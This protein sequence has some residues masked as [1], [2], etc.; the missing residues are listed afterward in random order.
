MKTRRPLSLASLLRR[1]LVLALVLPVMLL[2]LLVVLAVQGVAIDG[3]IY[4]KP[5]EALLSQQLAREVRFN[6]ALDLRL[7]V[8]PSLV[9]RDARIGQPAGFGDDAFA[10]IGEL[11]VRLDLW[12]LL[13]QRL[14]ADALSASDVRVNL[15]QRADGS[16]NW[17]FGDGEPEPTP[18]AKAAPD[19]AL[20]ALEDAASIDIRQVSLERLQVSFR[21]VNDKP[22][23]FALDRFEARV[24]IDGPLSASAEGKVDQ[25]MPYALKITGG[26]LRDLVRGK[27]DWPLTMQLEFAGG[28]L[29]LDG[30]LGP[31]GSAL[32]FG[33]GTP[34]LARF[35]RVIDVALPDAGSAGVAG[36]LSVAPGRV[37]LTELSGAL[38]KSSLRGELHVDA[39]A[40][41]PKL[42]GTLTLPVLDL[43]PFLGQ[44][45]EE[46][47]PPDLRALYLSLS[48]ARLDLRALRDAD[49]D[50]Q[51]NVERWLSLPGDIQGARLHLKLEDGRLEVPLSA[52]V[53]GVP[54]KGR[55][56][57]NAA[58]SLPQV[59]LGLTAERSDVGGLAQLLT[60]LPGI[61]G[62]LGRLSVALAAEGDRGETLMKKLSV[63]LQL[64]NSRLTYGNVGEG[65]PVAFSVEQMR[66]ALPAAG[67]LEGRFTG[68]LLGKPL[69]ARLSGGDLLTSMKTGKTPIEVVA[70]SG[71]VV[72]RVTG[73][74]DAN[75]TG[76]A[77]QFSLGAPQAGEVAAWLGL[78]PTARA[79]LA[80][81]GGLSVEGEQW[82]LSHFVFQLGQSS[83]YAQAERTRRDGRWLIAGNVETTR[84]DVAELE[85]LMASPERATPRPEK[86]GATL[87]I[88]VL[89]VGVKLDDADL[90]L[91]VRGVQGTALAVGELGFDARLREGYMHSSPFF[92][93]VGGHRFEGA[94]MLDL[95]DAEPRVQL[96]L[97]AANVDV[98]RILRDLKLTKELEASVARLNL[99]LDTH[100]SRLSELLAN[101]RQIGEISGGRLVVRD[102]N[103]G[104]TASLVLDR[105]TLS[106]QPKAP[107]T[108]ALSGSLDAIPVDLSLQ[109]APVKDLLDPARRV[110]F[111]LALAAAGTQVRLKGTMDRMIDKRDVELALTASGERFDALDKLLRVSLPPWGPWSLNGRFRMSARGYAV[112]D[113][114]LAIGSS[115]LAGRGSVDTT[116]ARPRL[117]IAL[118]S[119]LIQLDDFRLGGWSPTEARADEGKAS[120]AD[121]D[122]ALDAQ[123]LRKK[124]VDASDQV[125]GL[126]SPA[127][128]KKLE[129]QLSVNVERVLSGKD[130]LGSGELQAKLSKGRADI[131]PVRVEMPGGV[132][133]LVL[134]YEPGERDVQADLKLRIENF[135]YGVLGRRVKPGTDI[136]GRFT[137]NMAVSSRAPR[138]SQILEHGNG[139][140][141][142]AIW[143]K[144]L[145]A[146]VFD[147]WAV[148]VLVA[149]LPTLDPA[150]ESR[151]NCALGRFALENGKLNQRQLVIDTRQMRVTGNTL[152]DFSTEKLHLRLQPQAKTAQFLSLATPIEVRGSFSKFDVGARP[153]DIVETVVRLATSI[154]WVPIQ[155]L[156]SEKVPADGSDVCDWRLTTPA[157]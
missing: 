148:N 38:G 104:G 7:G 129:A 122:T 77:L 82:S 37:A 49:A 23:L 137:L 100:S 21:G 118:A 87:D 22:L 73:Q 26:P 106:V 11:Q 27:A 32:R 15:R 75:R 149:L 35:G 69:T 57:V 50:L 103:T 59:Q 14:R 156:F 155:K 102:P 113:L 152:I 101:A 46:E 91:R 125:Q 133:N 62:Q 126:L 127:T 114:Q 86:S 45:S 85:A 36:L 64:E 138:L 53:S 56:A 90:R 123:A 134:A 19:D 25:S 55:I 67:A 8:R 74:L 119:P 34:D 1:L 92:A 79:P 10:Q 78:S 131:G 115:R 121:K 6:G 139:Q 29:N 70:Q 31:R 39:T 30:H 54:L 65:R 72:A 13:Q 40:E 130:V 109:S 17:T 83:L 12:P 135:D 95:R 141:D 96:W 68:R 42:S 84:I 111:E 120:Q 18:E 5:L 33:L 117:D 153:G 61:D 97:T 48:K 105:G 107:L 143:P 154:V 144:N 3:A 24:P 58:Q 132:A 81:A 151:V 43:R 41:Q 157:P 99:Y 146:D 124:A 63:S 66:I 89:P 9:I 116:Q 150:N 94:L 71:Q 142:F 44:D 28:L 145:R 52:T 128:L 140:I 93:E 60:G 47:P 76:A 110:P 88:P 16:N 4:R 20:L 112:D 51:L 108:L 147:L 2:A 98:G 80:F 136:D